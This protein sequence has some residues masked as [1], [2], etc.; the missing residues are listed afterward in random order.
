V[1]HD[2]RINMARRQAAVVKQQTADHNVM[3]LRSAM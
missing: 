1:L 3:S 2:V